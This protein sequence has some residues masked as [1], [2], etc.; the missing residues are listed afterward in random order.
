MDHSFHGKLFW[1]CLWFVAS[2]R[3]GLTWTQHISGKRVTYLMCRLLV[4]F[5]NSPESAWDEALVGGAMCPSWKIS[6]GSIKIYKN[7]PNH[8]PEQHLK[9][10]LIR[11]PFTWLEYRH[12]APTST[13]QRLCLVKDPK[14]EAFSHQTIWANCTSG[15]LRINC[16]TIYITYKSF[17]W[18]STV[19]LRIA[20]TKRTKPR[21]ESFKWEIMK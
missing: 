6:M 7:V 12:W 8:Q 3:H 16:N 10:L 2:S 21:H 20:S 15:M 4:E 11:A 9:C 19:L 17:C 13:P 1:H 14:V 5:W 18:T